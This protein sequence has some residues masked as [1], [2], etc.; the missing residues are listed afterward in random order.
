VAVTSCIPVIP[1]ADLHK[2]LRFWVDGLGFTVQSEMREDDALV[3]CMLQRGDLYFMLNRR[4][5]S[6]AK[7]R[8][9]E[10]IRLYWTPENLNEARERLDR[11][12][13]T[14]SNIVERPYGQNEFFVTDDDGYS[15]CFGVARE[16]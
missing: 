1:S 2:S 11:L 13:F 5:G 10:G 8:D 9:Y 4:A 3:F 7:P 15:H 12:G 6:P 14:V 16:A